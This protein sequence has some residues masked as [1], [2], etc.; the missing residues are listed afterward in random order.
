MIFKNEIETNK[1]HT[2]LIYLPILS[3]IEIIGFLFYIFYFRIARNG[4]GALAPNELLFIGIGFLL[5]FV[6]LFLLHQILKK[7]ILDTLALVSKKDFLSKDYFYYQNILFLFIISGVFAPI[8]LLVKPKYVEDFL[9]NFL[10]TRLEQFLPLLLLLSI[11]SFQILF[12]LIYQKSLSVGKKAFH[13]DIQHIKPWLIAVVLFSLSFILYISTSEHFRGFA[14]PKTAYF[15]HL[16]DAFLNNRFHL[17]DSPSIKDLSLF[18][19]KYYVSFPPLAALLMMPI[20]SLE[21]VNA[22]NTAFWNIIFASFGV[23]FIYLALEQLNMLGWSNLARK[24]NILLALFLGFGTVQFFMG[25]RGSVYY[26]SQVLSATLLSASLWI[27]LSY[28][29]FQNKWKTI[30]HALL[31]GIVF[32]MILLARPNIGFAVI[33]IVLIQ[34]QKMAH[35]KPFPIKKLFTWSTLFFIPITLIVAGLAWY[36]QIRFGSYIDFGYRYM[37]VVD[38][39]LLYDLK[40][41]GQLHPHFIFR[42]IYDNFLRIPYWDKTCKVIAP[43]PHGMSIFIVSPLFIFLYRAAK[44]NIWVIGIWVSTTLILITHLLYFNSGALQYG[45]RFSLDFTPLLILLL[46]IS[47]HKKMNRIA[48]SFLSIGI[49]VNFIGVLWIARIWCENW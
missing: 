41:Y 13:I 35:E 11:L 38:P 48:L 14:T 23:A 36:N 2:K 29:K 44:R 28:R 19:G 25:T 31:T 10:F 8:I 27:A 32:S 3:L 45:Y 20:V 40:T 5:F 26:I 30:L 16:A 37:L 4:G 22:I 43:N 33:A 39:V 46:A 1:F 42:N 21:G 12:F 47:F 17:I 34:Y 15:P 7:K 6:F 49:V 24:Y 18:N 9:G